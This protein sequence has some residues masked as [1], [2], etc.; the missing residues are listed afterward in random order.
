M[1][2]FREPAFWMGG[3]V[4]WGGLLEALFV[5]DASRARVVAQVADVGVA[6]AILCA[7]AVAASIP[8]ALAARAVERRSGSD[9][10][11]RLLRSGAALAILLVTTA[12]AARWVRDVGVLLGAAWGSLSPRVVAGV[13]GAAG[14]VI[15][16]TMR[17]K[18]VH[19][20]MTVAA[21]A[22]RGGWLAL[23]A[24]LA[25]TAWQGAAASG[26]TAP[27]STPHP[28]VIVIV[29]DALR[30]ANTSAYGYARPTTPTLEALA[31]D[32]YLVERLHAN[33]NGTLSAMRSLL[34]G[35]RPPAHGALFARMPGY[36]SDRS[37]P[38]ELLDQGYTLGAVT[39]AVLASFSYVVGPRLPVTEQSW[40]TG[41]TL[42]AVF[43][44]PSVAE[45][46][47]GARFMF[48]VLKPMRAVGLV[49]D[50]RTSPFIVAAERSFE[51][52]TAM[53]RS[54]RQPFFL[55]VHVLEPHPPFHAL[56]PYRGRYARQS[57]EEAGLDLWSAR[58]DL[59]TDLYDESIAFID[60]ELG[61][62]L[63]AIERVS[64]R[65]RTLVAVTADHGLGLLGEPQG[66]GI[67][68][69]LSE[70]WVH[71]PLVVRPP[72]GRAPI[73]ISAAGESA[74]IAP[75][76]LDLIGMPIPD[77]MQGRSLASADATEP[78]AT[79]SLTVVK[80]QDERAVAVWWGRYK[81]VFFCDAP[82]VRAFDL[83]EDPEERN[84]LGPSRPD[85][86]DMLRHRL[87]TAAGAGA[88]DRLGCRV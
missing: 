25:V 38:A 85:L 2:H 81:G 87:S 66:E 1:K 34:T 56:P 65:D 37:L 82:T 86:V 53:A 24:M 50:E 18:A 14:L 80:E 23:C 11:A 29:F 12:F 43:G 7:V 4:A 10:A 35:L 64:P 58:A 17:R 59:H 52:A 49:P 73:R 39:S 33:A 46:P 31:R 72:G 15:G 77:W 74:D 47:A 21:G 13:I 48:D 57:V 40:W 70:H 22:A 42:P 84:D 8:V 63:D 45:T 5:I 55:Y 60:G 41:Q 26:S 88:L 9:A 69:A 61:R 19:A 28:N 54:L 83:A 44:V 79:I 6:L 78:H 32:G 3:A 71:V 16:L 68:V 76:I 20:L 30:S 62:F 36:W 27:A 67:G 75:T 51:R